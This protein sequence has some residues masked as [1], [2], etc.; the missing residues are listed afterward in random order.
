MELHRQTYNKPENCTFV[1]IDDI[2]N[3]YVKIDTKKFLDKS[4]SYHVDFIPNRIGIRACLKALAVMKVNQLGSF[5]LNIGR[6]SYMSNYD[7][8]SNLSSKF[9]RMKQTTFE[10]FEWFN[11]SIA[12]NYEQTLAIRNIVNSTGGPYPQVVFGP[13]GTGKTSTLVECV[14]Q[15]VKLRP[16]CRVLIATQSNSASDEIGVR[17]IKFVP[18]N[19]VYRF[20]SPSKLSPA[21]GGPNPELKF[22]SNL[23]D[24]RNEWPTKEE[25]CHFNVVIS[26]LITSSRLGQSDINAEHFDYIF[27]DEISCATE[28]EALVPIIGLGTKPGEITSNVV[29]L[30]DHLQLGPVLESEEFSQVLGLGVSFMERL[31]ACPRYS[32]NGTY[33]QRHV[34]QL[35][36]NYRSHPAIL[37]F[38]SDQFYEGRLRPKMS[39]CDQ[40]LTETW[41]FLPNKT[42][43]IIFHAVETPSQLDGTSSY[44]VGEV[45][46]VVSYVQKLLATKWGVKKLEELDIGIISPYLAQLKKLKEAIKYRW[47]NIEMGT[48][49]YFQGREKRVIIISTV[50][51]KGGVGFLSNE[52]VQN[53]IAKRF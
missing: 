29:L 4:I 21:S 51:S 52:K 25:I 15:I 42:F 43:P 37:K 39:A 47:P 32:K 2:Q 40:S 20:Y 28:P 35:L 53:F 3:D 24:K 10:F 23:R 12:N 18:I 48:A 8:M 30:G 17:L 19:K 5:F 46:V 26:T 36:D 9:S 27:V 7:M 49:E 33:N 31:M 45:N 50:K 1:Q 22:S 14:A 11:E 34:V 16:D 13:P 44:N 38:S 41:S 6:E